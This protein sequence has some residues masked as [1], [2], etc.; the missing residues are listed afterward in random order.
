MKDKV[1]NKSLLLLAKFFRPYLKEILLALLALLVTAFTVLFFGKA[2]KYLIDEGFLQKSASSLNFILF[3]FIAAT[4]LMAIAGYYRSSLINS[5]S[6]KAITDL[7]KKA[8][9]HI[10]NVSV[11]FFETFKAGDVISRLTTDSALLYNIIS[12]SVSFL[13]RNLILFIGGISFLFFT[14]VKLSIISLALIPLAIA[15]IFIVGRKLK[16]LANETQ[17]ATAVVGSHIEETINGIKTIQSYLC[18]EKEIKNFSNLLDNALAASLNKIKVRAKLV[19]SVIAASFSGIG[20]VLWVGGHEVLS[21]ELTSG[22][23]SSFIFYSVITATSLV[24]LSQISGQLQSAASAAQRIFDILNI[25]SPVKETANP[26]EFLSQKNIEIIFD[27]V[28]FSYPS[29]VE[30]LVLKNFDLKI[31]NGQKLAIVGSSGAGKSTILQLLLRFYDVT[32]GKILLNGIDIKLISLADLRK[33]FSYISQDCFIF[34]GTVLE[35]IAYASET[36]TEEQVQNIIDANPALHFINQMPQKLHTFVGEKGIKLSG[37]ERQRI[38]VARAIIKDSP[39]LLLDEATSALDNYNAYIIEQ[40][41]ANLSKEKTVITVAHKLSSISSM[42]KII[43]VKDGEISEIGS[44]HELMSKDGFY[45]KMY[46][47]EAAGVV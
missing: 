33:N 22:S 19:A 24:A 10:I 40:T 41:I 35:N 2:L 47:A 46:E 29:R 26:Q 3:N 30:S 1:S 38:A 34:S 32:S 31:T 39:I 7:R 12:N 27:K 8:Y 43:F 18:E 44:H 4:L 17:K 36:T 6:E 45:N 14:S 16:K 42:D 11:E 37:G 21:G 20:I 5:V 23:L 9:C 15:P 13:L 25:E 28:N